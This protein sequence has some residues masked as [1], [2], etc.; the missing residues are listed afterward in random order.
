M[1]SK[2]KKIGLLLYDQKEWTGGFYYTLNLI[3]SL[4]FLPDAEKPHIYFFYG[5]N[6]I[7]ISQEILQ[8]KYPYA[9][10]AP[11]Y[12]KINV[13]QRIINKIKRFIRK[14]AD[15]LGTYS[16]GTVDF[17][18][19]CL[20][21]SLEGEFSF[22]KKIKKIYWIPD[23]QD[24][25]Y[26]DFFSK[27]EL[28]NREHLKLQFIEKKVPLAFS[29]YNA[30]ADFKKF[31]PNA[32]NKTN[33]L[34][35]ASILPDI[36]DVVLNDVNRKYNINGPYFISP[37]QF[38]S[39]KNHIIVI[40]AIDIL[41]KRGMPVKLF[42]TGKEFNLQAPEYAVNLKMK[43]QRLGLDEN[44]LF[45]GFIERSEQLIL[46]KHAV[47]VIQPSLFEG[48]STVI[49]D[50]KALDGRMIVSDLPIHREQCT[51]NTE[52]FHPN[53]A[54]QL[55]DKIAA[56]STN[57]TEIIKQEYNEYINAFANDF[58]NLDN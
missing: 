21:L 11:L 15:L 12:V 47:A 27:E 52:F 42:F 58:L 56:L 30:A 33:V 6:K 23:F 22:L 48:W 39:H 9:S 54:E 4:Q 32:T 17:M 34:R 2:R 16:S 7:D 3:R 29:S 57:T 36:T 26:P 41:V 13:L 46:M 45:L 49:E 19:P 5:G 40:E 25:Y 44:I 10:Y 1:A 51:E 37:N 43:V 14:D 38:W 18:Y 28:E 24:K 20:N 55:A 8:I 53:D 50:T 35:F 31:Y